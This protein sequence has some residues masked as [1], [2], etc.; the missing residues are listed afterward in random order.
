MKFKVFHKFAA[1]TRGKCNIFCF[2][3]FFHVKLYRKT[4]NLVTPI[5]SGTKKKFSGFVAVTKCLGGVKF[6]FLG[7]PKT[8]NAEKNRKN[9]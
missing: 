7:R 2:V 4:P 8:R 3:L 5:E 6:R 1:V 9:L